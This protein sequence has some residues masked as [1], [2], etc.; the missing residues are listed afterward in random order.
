MF[1]NLY[2]A[3]CGLGQRLD[4]VERHL[5]SER[6]HRINQVHRLCR[7]RAEKEKEAAQLMDAM[8][9]DE[10]RHDQQQRQLREAYETARDRLSEAHQKRQEH[11][12][13]MHD[14]ATDEAISLTDEIEHLT[15]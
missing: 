12:D 9:G 7:Q 3:I 11:M 1:G 4:R 14:E 6:Q 10:R 2:R 5:A 8:V 13:A 15:A